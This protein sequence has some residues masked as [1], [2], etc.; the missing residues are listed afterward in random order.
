LVGSANLTGKATGRVPHENLEIL[1]DV[2]LA[3]PEVQHLLD[4]IAAT[5]IPATPEIAT[6]VREQ[7]NLLG[8]NDRAVFVTGEADQRPGHWYPTTRRPDRLFP[9]YR[10]RGD[11]S[12]AVREG[13]V[14]DLA[15]LDIAPGLSEQD[16]NQAVK[17]RLREMPE[18]Q[19]LLSDGSLGNLELQQTISAQTGAAQREA[20]RAAENIAAWLKYFDR[21]YT[22]VASWELRPGRELR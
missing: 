2:A 8:L 10:G 18:I 13:I 15:H 20:Q 21:Y 17:M 5:A 4:R 12:K 22:N 1:V 16:F 19:G 7:A 3:H 9:A 14:Y 11:F 6:S